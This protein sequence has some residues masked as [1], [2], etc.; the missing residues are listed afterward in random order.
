[1]GGTPRA[2]RAADPTDAIL[3][4]PLA[5]R[6]IVGGLEEPYHELRRAGEVYDRATRVHSRWHQRQAALAGLA[7]LWLQ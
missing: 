5:L 4:G 3:A 1:M 6:A 7:R 2:V